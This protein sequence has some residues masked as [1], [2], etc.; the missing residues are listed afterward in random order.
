MGMA[1]FTYYN[2]YFKS[3]G[4]SSSQIG[5]INSIAKAVALLSLPLWGI[6]ADYYKANKK[7]LMVTV[8][9]ALISSLL[10][11][12]TESFWLLVTIMTFFLTFFL[13]TVPLADAQLLGYLDDDGQQYGK[14]R[15]WGSIGYTVVVAGV[16]YF[17]E[18]TAAVNIFYL[19]GLVYLL[20]LMI[21]PKLPDED[22]NIKLGDLE[23]FKILLQKENLFIFILFTFFIN[24]TF[25]T[26][27]IYFPIYVI[28]QGGKE[29]LIG[30]S[31][32]I[33]ATSEMAIFYFSEEIMLRFKLKYILLVSSLAFAFRWFLLAE[34]PVPAVFLVSQLLHSLTFGLFHVTAVNYINELCGKQ[35]KSTGQ[36][37]YA[38]AKG[39]SGIIGSFIGGFI[40]QDLGGSTLYL[41]MSLIAFSAGL[42]YFMILRNNSNIKYVGS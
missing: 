20:T 9:G 14:Y 35:F 24:L 34:F 40:Y 11:L 19:S 21:I 42:I 37:L 36:N 2:L 39:I 18:K 30:I 17:V 29:F 38:T 22:V 28:D 25:E 31:L 8:S 26:N 32:M 10:F 7:L 41:Y 15:I 3:I 12:T 13:S 33:A 6:A 16:G 1:V 27:N 23:K 4:L 5:T